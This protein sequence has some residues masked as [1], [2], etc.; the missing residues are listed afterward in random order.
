MIR[1][2]L[3]SYLLIIAVT[4]GLLALT[5][6]TASAQAPDATALAKTSSLDVVISL[7][8]LLGI[9]FVVALLALGLGVLLARSISRPLLD[10]SRAANQIAQ[11][12]YSVTV[13]VPQHSRDELALL[14]QAFNQMAEGISR[15]ERLRRELVANVS[16]DLR[17]PLTVIRGYLEG[18]RS[19][20]IADRRSAEQAFEAMYGEVERLLKLVNKVQQVAA[21]DSGKALAAERRLLNPF[22]LAAETISR[23][24]PL[25][26]S[27]GV[28]LVNR[29]P[30]ALPSLK[31]DPEALGQALFNLLENALRH[32]PVGGQIVLKGG[33]STGRKQ[34]QLWLAVQDSGEGIAPE[35]LPH[36]FERFYRADASRSRRAEGGAGLGLAIVREVV[37]AHGGRVW[38]ESD[39]VPGHGSTFTLKLPAA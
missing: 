8:A 16:H 7:P 2:M 30:E 6:Q 3:L 20:Q 19:N 26:A 33:I 9:G 32:T 10:L 13:R 36:L 15:V 35:H 31:G 34:P 28:T 39:G 17:T 12:D 23:L 38:A 21:L 25:A 14:A 5:I 27:K 24:A 18:L 11:G 22:A 4:V 37:E 1:R 29:I